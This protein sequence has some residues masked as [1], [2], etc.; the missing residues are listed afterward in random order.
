MC[1]HA[2]SYHLSSSL[3]SE[4]QMVEMI[5][6]FHEHEKYACIYYAYSTI[7]KYLVSSMY[8]LLGVGIQWNCI[9]HYCCVCALCWNSVCYIFHGLCMLYICSPWF[10]CWSKWFPILHDSCELTSLFAFI[11]IL[12]VCILHCFCFATHCVDLHNLCTGTQC[13]CF[14]PDS[15]ALEHSFCCF[16]EILGNSELYYN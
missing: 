13:H 6:K 12:C 10:M 14:L 8:K 11:P 1:S 15:F 2:S 7:Q 3:F 4:T 5:K 9:I 16:I